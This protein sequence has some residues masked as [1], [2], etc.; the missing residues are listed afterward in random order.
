MQIQ[1]LLIQF[2]CGLIAGLIAGR[3]ISGKR[4]CWWACALLGMIG[5]NVG[6]TLF[7]M[8]H[9][10]IQAPYFLDLTITATVGALFVL[11]LAS[12]VRR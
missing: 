5:A 7:S 2:S 11:W 10:H 8:L 4:G 3:I 6:S 1:S 12:K 9:I